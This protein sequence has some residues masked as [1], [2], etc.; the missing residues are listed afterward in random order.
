MMLLSQVVDAVGG[1]ISSEQD[2]VLSGVSINTRDKCD[3]RLFVALKGENFDA[4]DFI[5][6]AKEAGA[7]AVMVDRPVETTLPS[8]LVKDTQ[9]ALTALAAWWRVQ[10]TI[11]LIGVTGSVGKTSV[12]EMLGCIFAEL[13]DGV[14][15]QGNLNNEVGVPLT[16]MRLD[17]SAQYAVIEMGMNHAGEISRITR[18]AQ[19]TIAIINNAAA[20]HLE[21]LGS[22]EAVAN[23]K[24]EIF[25]GLS[26]DGVAVI[27][28]DDAF[29]NQWKAQLSKHN[30]VTFALDSAADVTATFTAKKDQLLLD[31]NAQGETFKVN[32]STV[33][34][35]NAR[36]AVAAIAVA[37]A[38]N[39]PIEKIQLGLESYRPIGGRLN[40]NDLGGALIIDDTY[41]ANPLSM[42]AAIKVLADYEQTTLIVGDMAELGSAVEQEHRVLGRVAAE[43]GIQRLLACGEYAHHVVDAFKAVNGGDTKQANA[44]AFKEQAELIDFALKNINNGTVLVKGSR[45]AKMELVVSALTDTLSTSLQV[46]N[47]SKGEC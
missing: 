34:E 3:Q 6:Q 4:H 5:A 1:Q 32:L 21:G 11:P 37:V 46:S 8:I 43:H 13:G 39:V 36:N 2:V 7:A 16:L 17:S 30:V 24:A 33:G 45:S 20:A 12:K 15:T 14:V 38:A 22:I 41:N 26:E 28:N 35:H 18:M 23:A 42:L 19:P 40:L 31:V 44:Y 10:F 9:A 27:N 25:E 47:G 29:A